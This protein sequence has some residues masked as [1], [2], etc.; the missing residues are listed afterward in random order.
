VGLRSLDA[1]RL[2]LVIG[3]RRADPSENVCRHFQSGIYRRQKAK[4]AAQPIWLL[5][6]NGPAGAAPVLVLSLVAR[7]ILHT[8]WQSR[9]RPLTWSYRARIFCCCWPRLSLSRRAILLAA[10]AADGRAYPPIPA[11]GPLETV[12]TKHLGQIAE[13]SSGV[14]APYSYAAMKTL[15]DAAVVEA[16]KV[17][18]EAN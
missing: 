15:V 4:A 16:D 5:C 17:L 7:E 14:V 6:K 8:S 2:P 12:Y 10:I 11:W 18:K 1:G 9:R 13:L 3:K